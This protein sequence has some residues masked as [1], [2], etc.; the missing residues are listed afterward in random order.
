MQFIEEFFFKEPLVKVP[1]NTERV[2]TLLKSSGN[3]HCLL[4]YIN[5]S[6]DYGEALWM[7]LSTEKDA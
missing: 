3:E 5:T 1:E 6:S 7:C 2:L 4:F